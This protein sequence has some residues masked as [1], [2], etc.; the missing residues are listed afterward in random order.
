MF[1]VNKLPKSITAES[2]RSLRTNIKYSSID[3]HNKN[4]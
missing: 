4:I 3:N 2:Y 1:I